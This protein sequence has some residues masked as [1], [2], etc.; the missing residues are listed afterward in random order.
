MKQKELSKTFMMISNGNLVLTPGI[1]IMSCVCGGV[2][3]G[4]NELNVDVPM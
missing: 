2:A 4:M 1:C 3:V